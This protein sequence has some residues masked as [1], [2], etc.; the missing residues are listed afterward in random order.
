M[1]AVLV[2]VTWL[3]FI[4]LLGS[5][6]GIWAPVSWG[7]CNRVARRFDDLIREDGIM[8]MQSLVLHGGLEG[9]CRRGRDR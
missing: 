8:D 2:R 3:I 4:K 7:R 9:C 5:A 6:C 1:F